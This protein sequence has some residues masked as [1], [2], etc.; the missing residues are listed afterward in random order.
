MATLRGSLLWRKIMDF[1]QER[2][3]KDKYIGDM[4]LI[5]DLGDGRIAP[6]ISQLNSNLT[7]ALANI[8][9]QLIT[10]PTDPDYD[11]IV[12]I[13]DDKRKRIVKAGFTETRIIYEGA[14]QD[15]FTTGWINTGCTPSSSGGIYTVASSGNGISTS[16]FNMDITPYS[17]AKIRFKTRTPNVYTRFAISTGTAVSSATVYAQPTA[18]MSDYEVDISSLTGKYNLILGAYKNTSPSYGELSIESLILI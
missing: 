11:W 14:L 10:D 2:Y 17:T 6:A 13:K 12:A 18:V 5:K 1:V 16:I 4:D 9:V 8:S 7:K 3:L 15:G